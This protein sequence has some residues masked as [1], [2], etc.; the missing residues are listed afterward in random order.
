MQ[1][2]RDLESSIYFPLLFTPQPRE[3]MFAEQGV[4][5]LNNRGMRLSVYAPFTL[6]RQEKMTVKMQSIGSLECR[7]MKSSFFSTFTLKRQETMIMKL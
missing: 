3:A 2:I 6:H 5:G 1:S 7:G 4:R